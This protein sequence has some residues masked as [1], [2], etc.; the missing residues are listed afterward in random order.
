MLTLTLSF[1]RWRFE[2]LKSRCIIADREYLLESNKIP[3][4]AVSDIDRKIRKIDNQDVVPNIAA[5]KSLLSFKR[6]SLTKSQSPQ[7]NA[8]FMSVRN[9]PNINGKTL[10]VP[11]V[12]SSSSENEPAHSVIHSENELKSKLQPVDEESTTNVVE[13]ETTQTQAKDIDS[14]QKQPEE[15]SDSKSPSFS[16]V[17]IRKKMNSSKTTLLGQDNE[18]DYGSMAN[19]SSPGTCFSS[20]I[21]PKIKPIKNSTGGILKL[22][23]SANINTEKKVKFGGG[24]AAN[25]N[26]EKSSSV[27]KI[28]T[29]DSVQK[30]AIKRRI[31]ISSKKPTNNPQ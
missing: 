29:S 3:F 7:N 21:R 15:E 30:T 31:F 14:M 18:L 28:E 16:G 19:K 10:P 4:G 17:T 2:A 5:R 13:T 27:R 26:V 9:S 12:P 11:T 8:K 20:I 24:S 22:S 23:T 25:I 6:K 1:F